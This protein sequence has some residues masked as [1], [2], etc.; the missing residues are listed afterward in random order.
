MGK[1][2]KKKIS[3]KTSDHKQIIPAASGSKTQQNPNH[4]KRVSCRPR[5]VFDEE[6][7]TSSEGML[8]SQFYLKTVHSETDQSVSLPSSARSSENATYASIGV[9]YRTLGVEKVVFIRQKSRRNITEAM[10]ILQ[11]TP[12][13]RDQLESEDCQLYFWAIEVL[14][15]NPIKIDIFCALPTNSERMEWLATEHE[16]EILRCRMS[17]ASPS[18]RDPPPCFPPPPYE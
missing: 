1:K 5:V 16:A 17:N 10:H 8:P 13:F 11:R 9:M 14:A 7:P 2:K 18:L 3:K 4:K 6:R 15:Q 12:A